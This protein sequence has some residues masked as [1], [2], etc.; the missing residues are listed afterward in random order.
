MRQLHSKVTNEGRLEL[1]LVEVPNPTP[2]GD[3]VLIRIEAAPINPSDLG[4]LFGMA[5]MATTREHKVAGVDD[6]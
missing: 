3:E 4:L 6:E 5:D 2:A 1:S